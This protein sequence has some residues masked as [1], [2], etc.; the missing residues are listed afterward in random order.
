MTHGIPKE[1]LLMFDLSL[2][3]LDYIFDVLSLQ[4]EKFS[5]NAELTLMTMRF[6]AK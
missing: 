6:T 4:Q 5:K 1:T 2:C 3:L